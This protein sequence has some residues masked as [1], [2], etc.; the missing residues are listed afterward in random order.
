MLE[1]YE[2]H[3]VDGVEKLLCYILTHN[4]SEGIYFATRSLTDT[5]FLI[6]EM[7]DMISIMLLVLVVA[8]SGHST[9]AP[10]AKHKVLECGKTYFNDP[11]VEN[12][13]SA[14]FG[15]P[16]RVSGGFIPNFNNLVSTHIERTPRSCFKEEIPVA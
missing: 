15:Q 12:S 5:K 3:S 6:T 8:V 4:H 14:E 7:P 11:K 16:W 13:V 2:A 1:P 9:P 10:Q